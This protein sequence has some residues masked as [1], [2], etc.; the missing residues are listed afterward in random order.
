MISANFT[1]GP[2]STSTSIVLVRHQ[3]ARLH[4]YMHVGTFSWP[5]HDLTTN[6]GMWILPKSTNLTSTWTI[7]SYNWT[8]TL[9]KYKTI[10]LLKFS[11]HQSISSIYMPPTTIIVTHMD[12][13]SSSTNCLQRLLCWLIVHISPLS[14]IQ[15]TCDNL[16]FGREKSH[17]LERGIF[18][19]CNW[20]MMCRLERRNQAGR[21]WG[22]RDVCWYLSTS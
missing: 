14:P 19:C 13:L 8:P 20:I 12:Q 10:S 5:W 22:Q 1:T 15:S 9:P 16:V 17:H 7:F 4:P 11:V 21:P 6:I 3:S 2:Y 18:I